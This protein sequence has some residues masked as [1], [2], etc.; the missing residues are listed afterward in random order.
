MDKVPPGCDAR[1]RISYPRQHALTLEQLRRWLERYL[2]G[3]PGT[4]VTGVQGISYTTGT[5]SAS[6]SRALQGAVSIHLWGPGLGPGN[7]G[8]G[9]FTISG[10]ISDRGR[11][12]D[13]RDGEPGRGV[14]VF[15]GATG[16]IRITVGHFG[17][18]RITK[19]TKAYAGLRGRGTGGN[20]WHGDQGSVDITMVGTVS[21]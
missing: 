15:F 3:T 14:R 18:W 2:K 5:S 19:G 21:N 11:F 10:A 20:L 17:S 9:H 7:P 12:V 13:D 6:S 16:T 4:R 1:G 8:R